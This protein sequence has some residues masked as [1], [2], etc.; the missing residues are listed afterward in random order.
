MIFLYLRNIQLWGHLSNKE[1]GEKIKQ[2]KLNLKLTFGDVQIQELLTCI[3]QSKQSK[4]SVFGGK[5]KL[6]HKASSG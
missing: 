2:H 6:Q 3:I 5:G 1:K 4:P